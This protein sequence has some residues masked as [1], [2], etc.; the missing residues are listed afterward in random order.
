MKKTTKSFGIRFQL[1]ERFNLKAFFKLNLLNEIKSP[2]VTKMV[3]LA[4]LSSCV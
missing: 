4:Y 3:P 2:S 1:V